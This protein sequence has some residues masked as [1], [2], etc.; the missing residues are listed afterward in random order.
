MSGTVRTVNFLLTQQAQDGQAAGSYTLTRQRDFMATMA[1]R[2]GNGS[3][4]RVTDPEFGADP[5]GAADS[6][7]AFQAAMAAGIAIVPAFQP[8]GSIATYAISNCIV[9]DYGTLIGFGG[10]SYFA[11]N[12]TANKPQI[13]PFTGASVLF[14]VD[15]INGAHFSGLYLDGETTTA[16]ISGGSYNL[17]LENCSIS[18]CSQGLGVAIPGSIQGFPATSRTLTMNDC[19]FTSCVI[20]CGDILDGYMSGGS[21]SLCGNGAIIT[22]GPV[23]F[24]GVLF[25]LCG[26]NGNFPSAGGAAGYGANLSCFGAIINNCRFFS[27]GN[28]GILVSNGSGGSNTS[29]TGNLFVNN[30]CNVTTGT[31]LITTS[32]NVEL[33]GA[34]GLIM[35][36]NTSYITAFSNDGFVWAPAHFVYFGGT[37]TGIVLV[38]NDVSGVQGSTAGLTQL[39]PISSNTTWRGGTPPSG[40]AQGRNGYIVSK[41]LGTGTTAQDLDTR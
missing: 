11:Y 17:F 39:G 36:A 29:L 22:N 2:T 16:G 25:E 6:T 15:G 28:A 18:N 9:P 19:S 38:G 7:A 27:N 4:V 30:G 32:S 33:N 20:G 13:V 40:T 26:R 41:N 14:N 24:N 5:T 8:N 1:A 31:T 12:P 37:N 3:L 21:F 35:T 34:A 23:S 10:P